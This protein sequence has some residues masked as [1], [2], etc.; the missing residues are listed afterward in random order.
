MKFDFRLLDSRKTVWL[1]RFVITLVFLA[2]T[3]ATWAHWGNVR[4]DCGRELYVPAN[5]LQGKMLYRDLWYLYGPLAPYLTAMLF[6]L[7]GV[8]LNVLYGFGLAIALT[9]ALL[10]F[11]L[12]RRFLPPPAAFLISFLFL[13][14]GFHP[15]LFNYAFPY[16][17]AAALGSL[18]GLAC[19]YFLVRD[20]FSE[21]GPN[22]MLAGVNA[23]LA[24]LCKQE[25]GLA[26]Y[27]VLAFVLICRS[28]SRR[29]LKWGAQKSVVLLPG[30]AICATGYGWFIWKTSARFI[31]MENFQQIP[32][33][34]FMRTFGSKWLAHTG[35]SFDWQTILLSLVSALLCVGVWSLLAK[36]IRSFQVLSC[37]L[38]TLGA[39]C[40][41]ARLIGFTWGDIAGIPLLLEPVFPR[42]MA[43]LVLL[44]LVWK[45]IEFL[46]GQ[47]VENNLALAAVAFFALTVSARILFQVSYTGYAIFYNAFMFLP[48][49]IFLWMVI[50]RL[51]KDLPSKQRDR[52]FNAILL[53]EG[54]ALSL[55][56]I[57]HPGQL[58]ARLSTPLGT[59]FTYRS[60]A[61]IFPKIISFIQE[62]KKLGKRVL[63]L[64]EETLLYTLSGTEAPTRWYQL[65]PGILDP[66]Q[67]DEYIQQTERSGIA[68]I[69]LSNRSSIEYGVPSFGLDYNNKIY[70][71]IE[72]NY[73]VVG[74]EGRFA[75]GPMV[76]FSML[77]YRRRTGPFQPSQPLQPLLP[78]HGAKGQQ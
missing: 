50:Q 73:E 63:I 77:I 36:A 67:E 5:I 30:L 61:D 35:L 69:L 12:G 8:H 15:T 76:S 42:G 13:A 32:G 60:E 17:Y 38:F 52:I 78:N 10:L 18:L 26:C 16:S 62:Q 54:V 25:Y 64:P 45:L 22:F 57:P 65:T 68:F 72:Q 24:L 55:L 51:L 44:L 53:L 11:E 4:I 20:I 48:T 19:L 59:I 41:F 66:Q 1:A 3:W 34:F 75:R 28:W 49:L 6:F 47:S 9:F 37:L 21:P 71:W 2:L 56:L 33:S 40:I 46:C 23:G 43:W 27:F 7:C 39:F 58:P 29:S 14:Q 70:R 31:L 74:E